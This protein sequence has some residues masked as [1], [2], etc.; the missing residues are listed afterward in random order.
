MIDL[1][2]RGQCECTTI[3]APGALL[4]GSALLSRIV[5]GGRFGAGGAVERDAALEVGDSFAQAGILPLERVIRKDAGSAGAAL[6]TLSVGD[7]FGRLL[8]EPVV[9][10][11]LRNGALLER[12]N[13]LGEPRHPFRGRRRGICQRSW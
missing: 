10:F 8:V 5:A 11:H 6:R 7:Q 4:P 9:R 3:G 1:P 12:I 13:R 2:P